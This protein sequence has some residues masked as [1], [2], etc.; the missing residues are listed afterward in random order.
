MPDYE[1]SCDLRG[2]SARVA[3][4]FWPDS[5]DIQGRDHRQPVRGLGRPPD[6]GKTGRKRE[7]LHQSLREHGRQ[8]YTLRSCDQDR[9]PTRRSKEAGNLRG[10]ESDR[11]RDTERD[12][13]DDPRGQYQSWVVNTN[14]PSIALPARRQPAGDAAP[15]PL[16]SSAADRPAL[17]VSSPSQSQDQ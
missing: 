12:H 3:E 6:H 13:Q 9:L 7:G 11:H 5:T 2:L 17:P 16:E 8:I 1:E 14:S 10:R 4:R 15:V